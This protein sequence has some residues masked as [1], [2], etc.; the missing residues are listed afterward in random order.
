MSNEPK[1]AYKQAATLLGYTDDTKF[2]KNFEENPAAVLFGYVA[3]L[4]GFSSEKQ[5]ELCDCI[6]NAGPDALKDFDTIVKISEI[7]SARSYYS[8]II[9]A[10]SI[11]LKYRTED[12]IITGFSQAKVIDT[13]V[14]AYILDLEKR[15]LFSGEVF[16]KIRQFIDMAKYI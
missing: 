16:D 15:G 6:V 12:E 9:D 13:N 10:L 14:F 7:T 5:E 4:A 11:C 2:A 3:K 1:E 8:D